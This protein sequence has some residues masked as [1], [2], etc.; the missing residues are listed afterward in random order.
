[1]IHL[2]NFNKYKQEENWFM[3]WIN[4]WFYL[5]YIIYNYFLEEENKFLF[6][7]Y[8]IINIS[9]AQ[10]VTINMNISDNIYDNI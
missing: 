7:K 3:N 10:K 8:V 9:V 2:R 5:V 4:N 1:M 6:Q